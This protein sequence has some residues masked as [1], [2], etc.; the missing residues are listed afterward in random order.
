MIIVDGSE[1]KVG[2]VILPGIFQKLEINA[3][4]KVDELEVEGKGTKPKQATGYEDAK[5]KIDLLLE[6]DSNGD[7]YSKIEKLQRLFKDPNQSKPLV[8]ELYNRHCAIRGINKVIFKNLS[9]KENNQ[10]SYIIASL[11]FWEYIP[12]SLTTASGN[13]S[14]SSSSG[15]LT[16]EYKAYLQK[17]ESGIYPTAGYGSDNDKTTRSPAEDSDVP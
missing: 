3:D 12:I 4:A 13:T 11:E 15:G 7:E 10:V 1:V 6:A 17:R 14:S 9:T 8:Y 2:G 16:E 5:I